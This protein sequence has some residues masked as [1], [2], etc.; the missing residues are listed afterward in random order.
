MARSDSS[1]PAQAGAPSAG[2]PNSE[3]S[4][5][6][7]QKSVIF[8]GA[9]AQAQSA[10]SDF[11]PSIGAIVPKSLGLYAFDHNVEGLVPAAKEYDYVKLPGNDVLLVDPGSRKIVAVV[12]EKDVT[13]S[14]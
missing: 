10:P 14:K 7:A 6:S 3:V 4:L 11:H 8:R 2:D 9:I 12:G 13:G 1:K 5:S